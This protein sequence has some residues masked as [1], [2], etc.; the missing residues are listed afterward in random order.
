MSDASQV[1]SKKFRIGSLL[2]PFAFLLLPWETRRGS[3][4]SGQGEL[5]LDE[6]GRL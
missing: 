6:Y 4:L 1:K 5:A 3:D 2:L